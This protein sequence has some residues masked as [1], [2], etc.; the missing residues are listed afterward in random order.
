M[1]APY[2]TPTNITGFATWGDYINQI[3]GNLFGI[4]V[5]VAATI[6]FYSILS[7]RFSTKTAIAGTGFTMSILAI[8]WRFAG[9]IN[10]LTMFTFVIMAVVS[11][12]YLQFTKQ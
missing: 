12:L 7:L 6:I 8:I 4:L 1:S 9:M 2:P 3:T 5:L 11:I 10:D